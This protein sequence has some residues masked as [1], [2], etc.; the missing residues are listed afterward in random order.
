MASTFLV[1]V[2]RSSEKYFVPRLLSVHF[3]ARVFVFLAKNDQFGPKLGDLKKPML[4]HVGYLW[5]TFATIG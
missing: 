4:Q 2:P 3:A 5:A 1:A